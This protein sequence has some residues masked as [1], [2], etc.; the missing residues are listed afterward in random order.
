MSLAFHVFGHGTGC[1]GCYPK[2]KRLTDAELAAVTW[3]AAYDCWMLPALAGTY[4]EQPELNRRLVIVER[5][6]THPHYDEEQA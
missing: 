6:A 4:A 1:P 2:D 5:F 3:H